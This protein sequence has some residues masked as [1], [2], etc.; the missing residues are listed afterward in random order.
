MDPILPDY[1]KAILNSDLPNKEKLASLQRIAYQARAQGPDLGDVGQ[2][3]IGGHPDL[4]QD[5]EW[6]M[7]GDKALIFVAQIN[8]SEIPDSPVRDL[9]PKSGFLWIFYGAGC[10]DDWLCYG[11]ENYPQ[12]LKIIYRDQSIENLKARAVPGNIPEDFK[13]G[14]DE[15]GKLL[16]KRL[17]NT[18][19]SCAEDPILDK[20]GVSEFKDGYALCEVIEEA[21][22]ALEGMDREFCDIQIL[23]HPNSLQYPVS[24]TVAECRG[25][26][27]EKASEEWITLLEVA[28][29]FGDCALYIMI[30]IE[31]LKNQFWDKAWYAVQCT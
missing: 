29:A 19:I 14:L 13:E 8:F 9:L 5:I 15:P 22:S 2:S 3:R 12:A 18:I 7:W 1:A 26:N 28:C 30:R 20:L 27:P 4:P 17:E 11:E 21:E 23:G 25:T 24:P 6:P 31:D 10:V 16:F